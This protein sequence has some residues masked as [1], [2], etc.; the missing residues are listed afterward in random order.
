M[1]QQTDNAV[2]TKEREEEGMVSS[3]V[4]ISFA[5]RFTMRPSGVVS[6]NDIGDRRTF[7]NIAECSLLEI[8]I[9]VIGI[10]FGNMGNREAR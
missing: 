2:V 5:N 7:T 4:Y 6:K 8:N 10:T 1:V 3:T 9:M